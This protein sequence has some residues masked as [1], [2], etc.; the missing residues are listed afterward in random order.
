MEDED[1]EEEEGEEGGADG[2][3]PGISEAAGLVANTTQTIIP[4]TIKHI[5]AISIRIQIHFFYKQRWTTT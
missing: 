2:D 5:A 1:K 3:P 4:A